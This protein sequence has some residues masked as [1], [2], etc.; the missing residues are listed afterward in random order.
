MDFNPDLLVIPECECEKKLNFGKKVS[1]PRSFY[2]FGDNENKGLG[3]FS[4]SDWTI[5]CLDYH[6]PRFRYVLPLKLKKK[7]EEHLLLAVWAMDDK[8][9]KYRRYI[10]QVWEAINYYKNV[11]N[12]SVILIGDFN[13][14]KIW[15]TKTRVANHTNVVNKIDTNGI[16]SLYHVDSNEEQGNESRATFYLYRDP[17]KSYH[18]DYCFLGNNFDLNKSSLSIGDSDTWLDR[19]DHCP[20]VADLHKVGV[21]TLKCDNLIDFATMELDACSVVTQSAL[22]IFIEKLQKSLASYQATKSEELRLELVNQ[23]Y[24]LQQADLTI[25]GMNE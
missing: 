21:S 25:N 10:G 20:L 14:N 17:E 1:Q 16:K 11:L 8:E 3:V 9:N 24:E 23:I 12:D 5:E 6:N 18:I 4:Y 13:S 2:W 15:D 7:N 19:S 22:Q